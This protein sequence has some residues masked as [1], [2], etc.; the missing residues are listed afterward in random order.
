MNVYMMLYFA[1]LFYALTPGIFLSIP[2]GGSQ[3]MVAATHAAVFA[4]V[5][6]FTKGFVWELTKNL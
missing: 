5:A 6:Y 1:V 3:K 4:V 2:Q